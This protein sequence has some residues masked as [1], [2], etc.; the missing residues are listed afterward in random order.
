MT[1]VLDAGDS[2]AVAVLGLPL[3]LG[4]VAYVLRG[5]GRGAASQIV[6]NVGIGLGFF[7]LLIVACWTA[8]AATIPGMI[9]D[10]NVLVFL[11]PIY[12]LVV[13]FGIEHFLHPSHQQSIRE[14][15]RKVALFVIVLGVLYLILSR[16]DYHMIIWTNV[17]G[18]VFFIGA[19]IGILYLLVRRVV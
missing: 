12:L 14:R 9:G 6:A 1:S 10:T 5:Q 2:V 4:A 13:S 15:V 3:L 8:Y 17:L 16:L 19:L 18:F 11:A 7:S